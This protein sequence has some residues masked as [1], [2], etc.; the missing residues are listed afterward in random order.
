MYAEEKVISSIK[1][2]GNELVSSERILSLLRTKVGKPFS[3]TTLEEDIRRLYQSGYFSDIK[4]IEE[5]EKEGIALTIKVEENPIIVNI[6]I[7]GNKIFRK[8]NIR[9]ELP[10]KVGDLYSE[11][12][13]KDAVSAINDLYEKKGV[14]FTE[15]RPEVEIKEKKATIFFYLKEGK[16][17]RVTKIQFEGNKTFSDKKIKRKMKIKQRGFFRLGTFKKEALEEDKARIIA[18]YKGNGFAQV[19]IK[20]VKVIP[21]RKKKKITIKIVIDE[22]MRF[23]L[24]ERKIEGRLLFPAD[25]LKERLFLETGSPYVERK[26]ASESDSLRS[27]YLD[28]GYLLARVETIPVFNSATKRI[29][30][31]YRIEPGE[32]ISIE[33]IK[34]KGNKITKDNVLRRQL[35]VKPGEVFSGKKL[36]KSLVALSDL[37]YFEDID[38]DTEPGTQPDRRNLALKVDEKEKTGLFLFGAGYSSVDRFIGIIGVEQTNF[39]WKGWPHFVGGGQNIKLQSE[40]GAE[41][42]EYYLSFTNPWIFDKPISFGFDI[43]SIEQEWD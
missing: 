40:F 14:F 25:E 4:V 23:Y 15:I 35:K 10:F 29:D 3:K 38:V 6:S 9:K 24:G 37:G 32:I 22:G 31:T 7:R 11:K 1:V 5:E 41:K 39:D 18:F 30:V 16:R 12:K 19:Q 33:E 43:Y 36:R 13:L 20:E 21:D 26:V 27:Y 2:E 8:S 34:I 42:R 28:R 17:G